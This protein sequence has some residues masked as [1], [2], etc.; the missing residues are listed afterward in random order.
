M[1]TLVFSYLCSF[2][3]GLGYVPHSRVLTGLLYSTCSTCPPFGWGVSSLYPVLLGFF[4][5]P[6]PGLS[7]I[8]IVRV[9]LHGCCGWVVPCL[10]CGLAS[11]SHEVLTSLMVP[12]AGLLFPGLSSWSL[13][14]CCS[15]GL[16]F[17]SL[18]CDLVCCLGGW[19]LCPA[20]LCLDFVLLLL[21]SCFS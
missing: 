15:L 19:A 16:G 1:C 10:P 2:L 21:Q 8:G 11:L 12:Y 4:P 9:S 13:V 20:L 17:M 18:T 3:C 7:R 6:R 5:L 14:W